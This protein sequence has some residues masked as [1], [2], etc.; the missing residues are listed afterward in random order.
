MRVL[1]AG[2]TGSDVSVWQNFL[3]GENFYWLV[4]NS[5]FDDDTVQATRD[6]Q[7]V[8]GLEPTGIVDC[9][10]VGKAIQDGLPVLD[11]PTGSESG[12]NWPPVTISSISYTQRE[13]LFGKLSFTP[14]PT[15]TC[16]EN[17]VV[18]P[19]WVQANLEQ[20]HIPQL[21][22]VRGKDEPIWINK[23]VV[24]QF[25][26]LWKAWDD[27]GLLGLVLTF[28]GAWSPRYV[29]G[30]R[31]YLSS[32]SWG[33]A[34]DINFRWNM[35]GKTPA[36]VGAKGS[37]RK[38]VPIANEFGFYW[39][40]HWGPPWGKGRIDGMHFEVASTNAHVE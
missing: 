4:V 17:I 33:T 11:D 26:A 14:Q 28:D 36:L 38:L 16:P 13:A 25:K 9:V 20:V 19:T 34:M 15:A 23:K 37:V 1:Q 5:E 31:T 18:A 8:H 21:A 2:T 32:H 22:K 40:G 10:T 24:G 30:S 6:Y 27:A 35:L 7:R 12:P 29:R 39:G 3:V